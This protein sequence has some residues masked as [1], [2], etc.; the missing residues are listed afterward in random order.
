MLISESV[1]GVW[2]VGCGSWVVGCGV[3]V[4]PLLWFRHPHHEDLWVSGGM[5]GSLAYW[6]TDGDDDK[7]ELLF[8]AHEV[9]TAAIPMDNPYCSCNLTCRTAMDNPYCSCNLTCRTAIF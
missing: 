7:P 5:D 8:K 9:L 2:V 6:L 1:R 4:V 3:W